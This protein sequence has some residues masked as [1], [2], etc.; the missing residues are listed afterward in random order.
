MRLREKSSDT[1]PGEEFLIRGPVYVEQSEESEFISGETVLSVVPTT[2][3]VAE[4]NSPVLI[5][6][7]ADLVLSSPLKY[8]SAYELLISEQ[9]FKRFSEENSLPI[10]KFDTEPT[11]SES[12]EDRAGGSRKTEPDL[13]S[14]ERKNLL[15]TIG[16]L[17]GLM[18]EKRGRRY[19]TR[20][21]PN[22]KAIRDDMT[23]YLR[24]YGFNEDGL[25]SRTLD[26]RIRDAF[27]ELESKR[28]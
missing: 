1:P 12:L 26:D 20:A 3:T 8:V 27:R 25:K 6:D 23:N 24:G 10:S 2:H 21:E 28:R 9:E 22:I 18:I 11:I 19:G 7:G 5:P 16:V 14:R 13:G 17:A 4:D 15:A